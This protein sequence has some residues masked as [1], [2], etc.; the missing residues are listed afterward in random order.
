MPSLGTDRFIKITCDWQATCNRFFP[1]TK[2]INDDSLFSVLDIFWVYL[3]VRMFSIR[4][5]IVMLSSVVAWIVTVIKRVI[6]N[7]IMWPIISTNV[8]LRVQSYFRLFSCLLH[9][10]L[11]VLRAMK[12]EPGILMATCIQECTVLCTKALDS[13]H[14]RYLAV[15]F[16][17]EITFEINHKVHYTPVPLWGVK[18]I[19]YHI[20]PVLFPI[21]R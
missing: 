20:L 6:T 7:R 16:F 12:L 13:L 9:G 11:R 17:L 15:I 8:S 1:T 21:P 14:S 2:Q 18:S 19:F 10:H 4:V 5:A 3:G